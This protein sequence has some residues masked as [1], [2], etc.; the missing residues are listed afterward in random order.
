MEKQIGAQ[1][2]TVRA[3]AKTIED[4]EKTCK[5]LSEIGYKTVQISGTPLK[6]SEMRPILDDFGLRVVTTHRSFDDFKSNIDEII[7]YNKTLGVTLCGVGAMPEKP[8]TDAKAFGEFIE[9]ANAVCETL[10]KEN[11]YFGYH[12]HSFEFAKFDG[13][14]PFDRLIEET[15]PETFCF[16]VDTYWI[17]AG[18]L[19]PAD[20]IRRLGKRAMA[21]HFKD[22]GINAEDFKVP[23]MREVG[24]GNLDWD[25]IIAACEEAG[26]KW[27][28]VEQD[29]NHLNNDPFLSLEKSYEYLTKKGFC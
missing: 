15:N 29:S 23:V 13:K 18:G 4:F 21:V 28:L 22:Y 17:Q 6:A 2:Y 1:M 9:D 3:H 12:N 20:T 19:S 5:R 14:T 25:G 11:L 26:T 27:A 16:I 10:A 24:Y 8:R 7:D